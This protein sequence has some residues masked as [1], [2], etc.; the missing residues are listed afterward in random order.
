MI[1]EFRAEVIISDAEAW[2][3]RAGMRLGIPRIA[4]DHFGILTHCKPPVRGL[5]KL[6]LWRERY[7]YHG[8]M[9]QPQRVIV[10][11]FYD[12]EPRRQACAWSDR[13][14]ETRC[15]R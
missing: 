3:Q 9:G 6:L 10:S 5:D 8:L 2:T 15:W 4:F 12:V 14:C 7:A 11:S 13:C 1:R